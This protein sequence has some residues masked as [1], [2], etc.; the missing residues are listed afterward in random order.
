MHIINMK[1]NRQNEYMIRLLH[2]YYIEYVIKTK[3]KENRIFF[4]KTSTS[5]DNEISFYCYLFIFKII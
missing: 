5:L 1:L 3:A 4:K 2:S